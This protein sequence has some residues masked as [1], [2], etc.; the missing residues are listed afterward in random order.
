MKKK[1]RPGI[2]AKLLLGILPVV[3]LG[4]NAVSFLSGQLATNALLDTTDK[5]M[6]AELNG[7][8]NSI[9]AKLQSVRSSAETLAVLVSNTYKNDDMLVYKK[10]FGDFVSKNDFVRGSG[11]WFEP[12]VYEGDIRYKGEQYVGPYWYRDGKNIIEDWS[13][14]NASYDY[15]SQDYYKLAKAQKTNAAVITD[16]YYDEVSG[17]IMATCAAAIYNNKNEYIGCVT[18]DIDL[19]TIT[20]MLDNIKVGETGKARMV[21]ADGTYIYTADITKAQ[22]GINIAADTDPINTISHE[23]VTKDA[24][25]AQYTDS[26]GK[27]YAYF[28]TIPNVNWKLIVYMPYKEINAASTAMTTVTVPISIG[29]MIVSALVVI[30]IARSIAKNVKKV[31]TFAGE[32]AEGDFTVDEL[33]VKSGDEVGEMS[34]SLNEMYRNNKG[35]IG[36]ISKEAVNINEASTTLS[37]MS[38]ELSA[39]FGRIQDNMTNVNEAMMNSSAA[40]EEVSASVTEVNNSVNKLAEETARVTE[41]VKVIAERAARVQKESLVAHDSA[42][43]VAKEREDELNAARE[44]AMVVKEISKLADMINEI[45]DEI[46]LLSLNASIEAAR[47]GDAGR[48]FAVVAQQISKLATETATTVRK[49]QETTSSVQLAFT[50]LTESSEKLLAF[51]NETATP[52]YSKFTE[53]GRQ[54]GEDA[55]LFGELS[56]TMAEMIE[57]IRRT[58]EEVN[59][60]V[61]NIAEGT[62]D[63]AS[64]SADVT[65]AVEN[66]SHAIE[67]V[68]ELATSQ[69]F[70]ASTLAEIVNNF[71]LN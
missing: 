50:D 58:M 35:I 55:G 13:Y 53:I 45:A 67:S 63:T 1:K 7:N 2:K 16:P 37:A 29:V 40:T 22:N 48:G 62:E 41:E 70:T 52:D 9:D 54:Y 49:I 14:S 60:A 5:Y 65:G 71:K 39:E 38:Q 10:I 11:I 20:N 64:R 25:I 51:V 4:I 23:V 68:A 26:M 3:I 46:D 32:L 36:N 59:T 56:R 42:I 17:T 30:I 18:V 19:K 31:N 44:K 21:T 15:F 57:N 69:Q 47:A 12:K 34:R 43:K 8:I 61:Q 28:G 24:G 27:V 66:V 33:T 6:S